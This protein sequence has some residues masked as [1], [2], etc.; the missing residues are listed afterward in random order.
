MTLNR[1]TYNSIAT[2]MT[3]GYVNST[4]QEIYDTKLKYNNSDSKIVL[5]EYINEI[6]NNLFGYEFIGVKILS[7]PS[8]EDAGYFIN[9]ITNKKVVKDDI[10]N[11]NSALKFILSNIYKTDIYSIIFDGVASEPTYERMNEFA[12]E[13]KEYPINENISEKEFYKPELLLG[14]KLNFKFRL[15]DCFDSCQSC[16]ELS[17]DENNQ[18]C[19]KYRTGFYFKEGTNNS[20]DKIEGKYYFD[21]ETHMF[22]PCFDDCLTCS[23][24]A[25]SSTQMNC[26]TCDYNL[27]YYNKSKKCLNCTKYA[28]Y[29]Q[30]DCIET[31]PDGYYLADEELGI[32]RKCYY[33]CKTCT[34]G[35]YIKNNQLYMNCK[36]CL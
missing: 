12:E 23:S 36:S 20:Y 8:E 26:L 18:K 13:L 14:K 17:E 32:L 15:S 5:S 10:L 34:Q 3:F 31:I 1:D 4:E 6:E 19:I 22:S 11:I 9:N 21:E 25:I 28:N 27:K 24:K 33:L 16:T 29:E 35:S 30:N 2:F 7:L